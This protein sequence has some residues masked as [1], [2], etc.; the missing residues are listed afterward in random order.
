MQKLR[1]LNNI[2]LIAGDGSRFAK[3]GYHTPKPLLPIKNLPMMIKVSSV[4]NLKDMISIVCR[5]KHY[6]KYKIYDV[7]KRN[8]K[9]FKVFQLKRKTNGQ[10]T[11]CYNAIKKIK[12]KKRI[13]IVSSDAYFEYDF[14]ELN[15]LIQQNYSI[16]LV[17]SYGHKYKH[18]DYNKLGYVKY[19]NRKI[20]SISCKKIIS[21]KPWNDL[22]I[23][24]S[25]IFQNANV[26]N[27]Y[28]EIIKKKKLKLI[29]N[30][31]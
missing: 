13:F 16:I 6:I 15:H 2:L 19:L 5:K 9:L 17:H 4:F 27:K 3:N 24:G 8:F 18:K 21:K 23:I 14:N 28:Y 26:Y 20:H 12:N 31:T 30:I 22:F 7:L 1:N 11:S 29:K 10:A 25:F